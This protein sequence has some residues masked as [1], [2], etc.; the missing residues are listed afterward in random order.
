MAA[1]SSAAPDR[2][3]L[4]TRHAARRVPRAALA[5]G[6][7]RSSHTSRVLADSGHR[8]KVRSSHHETMTATEKRFD[9]GIGLALVAALLF[10]LSA[11]FAKGLLEVT[12][13]QLLAGLLY[14]GSGS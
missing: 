3:S 1:A 13:P 6:G 9:R 14:L 12:S 4:R 7:G 8:W 2:E 10:G 11:P 5:F